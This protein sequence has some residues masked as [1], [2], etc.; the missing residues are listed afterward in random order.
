MT[1]RDVLGSLA[2]HLAAPLH[3]SWVSGRRDRALARAAGRL[4]PAPGLTGLDVGC[5]TGLVARLT[6]G[7]EFEG[8]DVLVRPQTHIPVRAF[9]GRTLPYP[10]RS[11]DF[12]MF[13][14]VL[15]HVDDPLPLLLEARRVSRRF[16][17]IKDH[18]CESPW[19]HRVLR[20]MDWVGNRAYGVSLPFNYLSRTQWAHLFAEAGLIPA[21]RTERLG[22]Y[23]WPFRWLF[24][25]GLHF[26]VRLNV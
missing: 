22:L 1:D 13:V 12:A 21:E 19:D 8:C 14:D 18:Y 16:V 25:T 11:F 7:A 26:M 17:L 3:R 2:R 9:N 10:D 5:G 4:L 24:E 15:H 23:P 20:F 6:P